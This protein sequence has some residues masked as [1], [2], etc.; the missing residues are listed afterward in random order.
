MGRVGACMSPFPLVQNVSLSYAVKNDE[1]GQKRRNR[2]QGGAERWRAS[3]REGVQGF[4]RVPQKIISQI[5]VGL[6][7]ILYIYRM[8]SGGGAGSDLRDSGG[9]RRTS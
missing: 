9:P 8:L 5:S 4:Y 6:G 7:A 1:T 3:A 2:V